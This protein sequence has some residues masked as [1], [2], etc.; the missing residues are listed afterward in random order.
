M[1]QAADLPVKVGGLEWLRRPGTALVQYNPFAYGRRGFA[2]GL[3]RAIAAARRGVDTR[4]GLIVHE[5]YVPWSW[6]RT[7]GMATWQRLQLAVI[8]RAT[9]FAIG[10]SGAWQRRVST[11][12]GKTAHYL[13][14]GSNLPDCRCLREKMRSALEIPER[15]IV[16]SQIGTTHLS[17]TDDYTLRTLH[18]L[19]DE[20]HEVVFV[21]LGK[22]APALDCPIRQIRPGMLP[23]TH[24]AGLLATADIFLSPCVDGVT[25][26]RTSVMAA[27]QHA[28]PVIGTRSPETDG[29][30][31]EASDA[32]HLAPV[33]DLDGFAAACVSVAAHSRVRRQSSQAARSL[34]EREFDWPVIAHRL[35]SILESV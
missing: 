6:D 9:D 11:L 31:L 21:N 26:R 35:L 4:V 16:V 32:L 20:Q 17:R 18:Q 15:A 1:T 7:A 30:L 22:D 28:V 10:V 33:G 29:V 34:Y 24:L 14:V 3:V 12:S 5:P 13:P 25:T 8:S 23:A 27:L 2:P 19:A